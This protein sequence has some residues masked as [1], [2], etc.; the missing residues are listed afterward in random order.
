MA[1]SIVVFGMAHSGKSTCIGY[2]YNKTREKDPTYDFEQ[3]VNNLKQELSEYDSSR[4]YGY[5]V[6]EFIEERIKTR[7][8]TGTSKKIHLKPIELGDATITVIDTPGSEH[9]SKQRQKGMYYG[10]IGV[11]CIEINQLTS[12]EFFTKKDLFTTF[13]ATLI[14]WSKFNRRTI[15]ALTKMDLC[16]YKEEIYLKAC[17]IISQ[18]CE[19]VN[20]SDIIPISVNVKGRKAHNIYHRSSKM[21]WYKG[22]S[23]SEALIRA[24]ENIE[25]IQN[26]TQLLFY[27]DRSYLKSKQYTGQSWRI[28]ILQGNINV[29]QEIILSPVLINNEIGTI[30]AKIK[31]I[32]ADLEKTNTDVTKIT[33]AMEGSFVGIDLYD[34]YVGNRRVNKENIRTIC[35]SCGFSSELMYKVSDIFVFKTNFI[36]LE[37]V[38]EG[39]QMDILWFGR[40]V[41]FQVVK[42]ES[43]IDGIKVTGRIMNKYIS[44]PV[45]DEGKFVIKDLIIRYDHN[46]NSN[47]FLE[48]ELIEIGGQL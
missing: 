37:K 34:I 5:L 10:D 28:K 16:E 21:E 39:R 19:M 35:T 24:L 38:N 3:Y 25:K 31:S 6:D 46:R 13:M 26:T 1:K 48:A 44:M 15:I 22:N 45:T 33:S 41:T 32:R 20:V 30:K 9:K 42:R 47:P 18:L 11:F 43:V 14:L 23:L 17:A 36:N 40:A 4:D 8:K 7:A 29:N 2:M 12:E 27:V